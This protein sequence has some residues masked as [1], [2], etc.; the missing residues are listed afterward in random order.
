MEPIKA[1]KHKR[2]VTLRVLVIRNDDLG[3]RR[4]GPNHASIVDAWALA[5]DYGQNFVFRK[6]MYVVKRAVTMQNP[7]DKRTGLRN[8]LPL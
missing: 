8:L 6:I 4:S 1:L 2:H 7:T 3:T 5:F